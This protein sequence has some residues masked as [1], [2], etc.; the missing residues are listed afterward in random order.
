VGRELFYKIKS[1]STTSSGGG[2]T[3]SE[4]ELVDSVFA[5]ILLDITPEIDTNGM[6]TLKINPSISDTVSAVETDGGV[7]SIPPDL[8]RRQIASVIKVEDGQHAI[9]GGLISSKTGYEVTKIPLL[10]DLPLLEYA[11]KKEAKIN[12]VEELVI[13][14]TPHVVKNAKSVSLKDLGYTKLNEK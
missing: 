11:F 7:R 10:G 2:S 14:I 8:V 12:T 3:S 1:S 13:I 9:L 4:G 5:G 6:I